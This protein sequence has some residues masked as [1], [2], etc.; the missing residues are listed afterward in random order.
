MV[1]RGGIVQLSMTP[2]AGAFRGTLRYLEVYDPPSLPDRRIEAKTTVDMVHAREARYLKCVGLLQIS[3]L[4]TH[5]KGTQ[6]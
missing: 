6:R 5:I 3:I 1:I 2:L 4:D